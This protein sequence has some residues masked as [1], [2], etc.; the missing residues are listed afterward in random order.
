M[1]GYDGGRIGSEG[2][3]DHVVITR[4]EHIPRIQEAQ[5]ERLP[6]PARARGA[7][8]GATALMSVATRRRARVR[9]E[10]TVQGVGF[11]PYVHRLAGELGLAGFVLNDARGRA[12]RDRGLERCGGD[13]LGSAGSVRATARAARGPDGRRLRAD[14]QRRLRDP[15][16]S[17]RRARRRAVT[18][19]SATCDDCLRE[20]LDP[21]RPPVPLPVHQLHQL[22][23]AVHDRARRPLR[24]PVDDD[25][26]LSDVPCLP[27][28]VRGPE[29]PA[30]SRSA[31]RVPGLRSDAVPARCWGAAG[32]SAAT[33]RWRRPSRLC[34][35]R[36]WWRSRGSAAFIWRAAPMTR[37]RWHA[38]VAQAP[39]GQAVRADGRRRLVKR[40]ALVELGRRR[41]G[42]AVRSTAPDRA[43]HSRL[44]R[45][46]VAPAVAPG[47][48]ELGVMLP[49]SPLHHLLLARLRRRS[50]RDDERQRV[51]RADRLPRR[52]RARAAG[53]DR[54]PLLV[55]DRPIET[56]TDDSVARVVA[57]PRGPRPLFVRRSRGYVPAGACVTRGHAA[58][59][60]SPAAR[61]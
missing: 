30:V 46:R 42:A 52:G 3:A 58:P 26:R 41:T 49:Y 35:A 54:R 10:G 6:L 40:S 14:R 36:R 37:P 53:R 19:D 23:S 22:R 33:R 12:A 11:R 25:G 21:S 20:L 28:R 50:A 29:R 43:R 1:V 13:V 17:A 44:R 48:P 51:R 2:I 32:G 34:D 61:S 47:A 39:R 31:Q 7:S 59:G 60:R 8:A 9:V 24:P 57:G 55:H 45:R 18:P 4:S 56:R 15:P 16:E 27:R 38:A 5:A